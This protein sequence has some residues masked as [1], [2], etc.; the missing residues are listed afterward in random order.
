LLPESS[1]TG[2][3][4]DTQRHIVFRSDDLEQALVFRLPEDMQGGK[5]PVTPLKYWKSEDYSKAMP[6]L[7]ALD[8][9]C[10]LVQP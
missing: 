9:D 3:P 2:N 4:A 5:M 7:V 10:K 8:K 6:A 1:C